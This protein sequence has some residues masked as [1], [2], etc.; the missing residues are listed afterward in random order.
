MAKASKTRTGEDQM[1][2]AN[3]IAELEATVE[4]LR[5]K[6]EGK[7]RGP[8]ITDPPV[9]QSEQILDSGH[10]GYR[11]RMLIGTAS[12]GVIRMEWADRRFHQVV[13]PNWSMV[14]FVQYVN[15]FIAMR[16]QVSDAQNLIVRAFM[17]GGDFE[18]LF[19]LE[20]DVLLPNN[21]LVLLDE[22][23]ERADTPVVSGLYYTRSRPS[24]PL[25]YRGRGTRYYG[26]NNEWKLGDLVWCDGVPTGALLIHRSILEVMWNESEEYGIRNP[27]GRQE[28]TR[29]VFD[30]PR[31]SWYDPE[32]HQ[33]Q[34]VTGTTDLHWC[35]RVIDDNIFEKA[36]WPEFQ[37]EKWPFVVDTRLF[38]GHINIDG[39]Q[40][41]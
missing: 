38:C 40:F 36:G 6:V 9:R 3:R 15:G 25:I 22:W 18:W 23:M 35:R 4:A 14:D 21:A 32:T 30:H 17:E 34:A 13:P 12:T 7:Y 27:N 8:L 33:Y 11:H 31:K 19:L 2:S 28:N 16:Y 29:R 24:E 37:K 39:E 1:S 10:D 5:E 41:P 26:Q 20:H